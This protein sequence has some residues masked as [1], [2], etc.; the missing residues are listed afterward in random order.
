M[1]HEQET[2]VTAPPVLVVVVPCH[3][4][5]EVLATTNDRLT[6]LLAAMTQRK[7]VSERSR[8]L[9]VDDGSADNTWREIAAFHA[10]DKRVGGISLAARVGQQKALIAGMDVARRYGDAIVSIDADLQDDINVIEQMVDKYLSGTDIVYGV[11]DSRATDTFFKK[12]SALMFYKL[13]NALGTKTIYNHADYRLMS[14]RAA[15]KLLEFPE[16]NLFIRGIV[17]LIGFTTDTVTYDRKARM[18]GESKYPLKKM[19]SFAVNGITSF[20]IRPIRLIFSVGIIMLLATI[21]VSLYTLLAYTA[22]HTIKGWTSLMLSLWFIGSLIL[23]S[24]GIIGEYIGKIHMEVKKRPLYIADY[25]TK[26]EKHDAEKN[27]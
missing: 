13:M 19:L 20:S 1:N 8:I 18:A 2:I 16:R 26:E 21:A 23:I 6:A 5:E 10:R 3:N 12:N 25:V 4:E 17:P 22:G 14:R 15:E 7:E 9:Y 11:R 27:I 24:L